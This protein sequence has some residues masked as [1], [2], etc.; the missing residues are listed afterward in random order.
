MRRGVASVVK[1]G[2][3]CASLSVWARRI[4]FREIA[5]CLCDLG[6]YRRPA[7]VGEVDA[8]HRRS[9]AAVV[10]LLDEL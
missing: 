5:K 4:P 3:P 6:Q 7:G 1:R 2:A 9:A 8:P 10:R